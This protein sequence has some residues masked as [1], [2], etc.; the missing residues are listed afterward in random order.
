MS[1]APEKRCPSTRPLW[2]LVALL[3]CVVGGAAAAHPSTASQTPGLRVLQAEPDGLVVAW[4]APAVEIVPLDD[5]TVAVSAAGYDTREQPG[6][7]RLPF[8]S[9]LIAIPPGA[10]PELRVLATVDEVRA[11]DAPVARAAAPAG[12]VRDRAG[13]VVGGAFAPPA[14]RAA[15]PAPQA[16][17]ALD[18]IGVMRGVRLARLTFTP[19]RL[20]GRRLRIVRRLEVEIRWEA[21]APGLQ[22][23]AADPLVELVRARVLN[24][25][26]VAPSPRPAGSRA[27]QQTEAVSATAYIEVDAPGLYRVSHQALSGLG[28]SGVVSDHVHLFLGSD[29][30]DVIVEDEDGLFGD[31]DAVL[32]TAQPRFS[33]WTDVDVYRLVAE[34]SPGQRML[35]R[36]AAS[37]LSFGTPEVERAFEENHVYMPDCFC[38]QLPPGRDGDRWAWQ[39]IHLDRRVITVTATTP[40]VDLTQPSTLTLWLIGYTGVA[41]PTTDH[42]VDVALNGAPLGRLEWDGKQAITATLAIS[43]GVLQGGDNELT[44]TLPGIA[45]VSV[46]GAWLDAF[47]LRHARSGAPV[48]DSLRFVGS[49]GPY[50]YTLA[51]TDTAGIRAFDVTDPLHPVRLTDLV[52]D[53]GTVTLGDPPSGGE[54]RYLALNAAGVLTPACVRGPAAPSTF[55]TPADPAGADLLVIT[56]PDFAAELA[57]LVDLRTSQGLT[58]T[59]VNVAWIYDAWGEG[60]TDPEAIRAFIAHAYDTWTPRPTYV[61]LVGDGTFD[62]QGH[63]VQ[64]P[65]NFIP[66][67]LADVDPWAGETAADNQYACVHGDDALPDLMLGRLPVQTAE[68][69]EAVVD[70]IVAYESDPFPGPWNADVLLVADDADTAGDFPASVEGNAAV[71]VGDPFT[72]TRH[73]CMGGSLWVDDCPPQEASQLRAALLSDWGQG[74]FVVHFTGHASWQQWAVQPLLHLDDLA[75]L[76]NARRLPVVVEMTCFTGAYQRP[77]PTL[78]EEMVTLAGGGAVGGWAPTGLGVATGHN[79]LTDGFHRAVFVDEVDTLGEATQAGKLQLWSANQHLDLLDTYVLL[80]DPALRLNRAVVPWPSQIF[81]PAVLRDS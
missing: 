48:A 31:G 56:H 59:V 3:L 57:P 75:D 66:S 43:P 2:A 72:V 34:P 10:V 49:D 12:V 80:G 15:P 36:S 64:P 46:E 81:L 58:P 78:A 18:E 67:Y 54:H 69:A 6:V 71:H 79:H 41:S 22:A 24:P 55:G 40:A 1:E 61:L 27:L 4:Q 45:G 26:H 17:V 23:E 8:T 50:S 68:Q 28:F 20:E 63:S 35:T 11:L 33:R 9:T 14:A 32:F 52:V 13:T 25:Q 42:R 38:G 21:P 16:P 62:P 53:A 37:G 30:V 77:E 51:F 65:T 74:A 19:A 29:E 73:Y 39:A 76:G 5:G 44:L 60:R 70:K 7:P 47:A